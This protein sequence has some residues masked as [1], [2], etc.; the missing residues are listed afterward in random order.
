MAT[1]SIPLANSKVS[2][3]LLQVIVGN[4]YLF[5]VT[6]DD[7]NCCSNCFMMLQY[8]ICDVEIGKVTGYRKSL[9]ML[10]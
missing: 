5:Y 6:T 4:S 3:E 1:S 8:M 9:G 7:L 2:P 10:K